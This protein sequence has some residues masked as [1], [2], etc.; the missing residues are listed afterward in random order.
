MSALS[1]AK[2]Y[3][4]LSNERD[5]NA[6]ANMFAEDATYSSDNRGLYFG[7]EDI[8]QMVQGFFGSFPELGWEI[9]ASE[10]KTEHIVEIAFTFTG[11]DKHGQAV[12]RQGLESLVI[13]GDKI[14]HVD[15]RNR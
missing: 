8:M 6:I 15:V 11:R 2:E 10:E 1:I 12:S 5:L 13:Q 7:R 3:F 9:D 4:R 14:R